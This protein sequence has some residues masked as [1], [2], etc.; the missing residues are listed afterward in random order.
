M[1]AFLASAVSVWWATLGEFPV[2]AD[3]AIVLGAAAWGKNPSPVLRERANHAISLYRA[4]KVH[5]IVC[6]GGSRRSGFPSEAEV[7]CQYAV[8]QEVAADRVLVETRSKT[9]EEN[10][11]YAQGLT[12]AVGI[13]SVALVSDDLHMRRAMMLARRLGLVAQPA[14]TPTSRFRTARA[15]LGFWM[16][17]S[18]LT[19]AVVLLMPIE[20]FSDDKT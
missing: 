1:L 18:W 7:A 16:R 6:T 14:P 15:T 10:L 5:W 11:L 8:R 20:G 13:R 19:L 4:G 12:K 17:E 3:A 9:T 2:E